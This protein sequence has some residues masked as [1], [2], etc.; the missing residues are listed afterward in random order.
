MA[1]PAQIDIVVPTRRVPF[2]E[3]YTFLDVNFTGSS[4]L[5]Q[6]REVKD[7]TGAPIFDGSLGVSLNYAGTDSVANHVAAGRLLGTGAS[8]IYALVNTATGNPYVGTDSLL[9]S[10]L[11]IGLDTATLD[12]VPFPSERGDDWEG[13]HDLVRTP[14]SGSPVLEMR[15]KF[16]VQSAVSIP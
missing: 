15:G 11:K 2:E 12:D 6:V 16:I 7:T 1:T 8:S 3:F 13:W 5:F 10:R 4:Y 9:L 14:A